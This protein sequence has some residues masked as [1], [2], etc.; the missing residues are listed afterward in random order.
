[1]PVS[2]N[3]AALKYRDQQGTYQPINSIKGDNGALNIVAPAY[4]NLT[5]PVAAGQGCIYN[6]L[7]YVAKQDITLQES[8]TSEHWEQR[9]LADEVHGIIDDTAGT[10]DTN[11]TFSADKLTADHTAVMNAL[12]QSS[13]NTNIAIST[14]PVGDLFW[15]NGTLHVATTAIAVGDTIVDTGTGANCKDTTIS[16]ALIKDI[17]VNGVSILT[18]G[19]ANVPLA[20]SSTPGVMKVHSSYGHNISAG[21][22]V[23]KPATDN[24]LKNGIETNDPIVPSI[25]HKSAFFALAKAAGADMKDISNPTVGQYPETQK[26]A[27]SQ[28]LN[29]AVQVTGT[30][31]VIVAKPGIPYRC[32]ECATLDITAPSSGIVDVVF[33]SGSTPTVLTVTPPTGVI[34]IEWANGFDPANLEANRTYELKITDGKYGSAVVYGGSGS[35]GNT[36]NWITLLDTTLTED[37]QSI[38]VPTDVNGNAFN[39][40]KLSI[41]ALFESA[42]EKGA[43]LKIMTVPNQ[44]YNYLLPAPTFTFPTAGSGKRTNYAAVY[45]FDGLFWDS[46]SFIGADRTDYYCAGVLSNQVIMGQGTDGKNFPATPTSTVNYIELYSNVAAFGSGSKIKIMGLSV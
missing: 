39:I 28:M 25:Q 32:G 10:G 12:T 17:Q 30:T 31:P 37:V 16:E 41:I 29:G 45:T 24:G 6:D 38:K 11:V 7:Y 36:D 44:Q 2:I 18:D 13:E 1:M 22:L 9:M 34:S 4:E 15:Y 40:K 26:S 43:W 23:H 19:V 35:S 3:T 33:E 27:I 14:H 20:G 42:A 8:W 46:S 5:Y 21:V